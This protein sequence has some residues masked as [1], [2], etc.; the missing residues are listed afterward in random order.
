MNYLIDAMQANNAVVAV[1]LPHVNEKIINEKVAVLIND[2]QNALFADYN[3]VLQIALQCPIAGGPSV[4][5]ARTLIALYNDTIE[6]DDAAVCLLAGYT[7]RTQANKI[8][9][10]VDV[11]PN[12]ADQ[13]VNIILKSNVQ[14]ICNVKLIDVMGKTVKEERFNCDQQIFKLHTGNYLPGTYQ[15]VVD[16]NGEYKTSTKLVIIR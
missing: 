9:P 10:E 11:I 16:I 14:G 7:N 1:D 15:V 5:R 4:Y 3:Q 2:G 12:P 13:Y 6:Y 8:K